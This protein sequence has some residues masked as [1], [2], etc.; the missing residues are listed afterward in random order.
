LDFCYYKWKME[1]RVRTLIPHLNYTSLAKLNVLPK[2]KIFT[3]KSVASLGGTTICPTLAKKLGPSEYGLF[4]EDV[5]EAILDNRSLSSIDMEEDVKKYYDP[6]KFVDLIKL[7]NTN[8]VEP[9][10]PQVEIKHQN[11]VGHPD[12]VSVTTIYDIKTTG[13]FGKMRTECILQL[14]SYYCLAQLNNLPITSVSLILP[15]QLKV[16]TYNISDWDWK[17]FY[18]LLTSCINNKKNKT[19]LWQPTITQAQQF[20]LL[21]N[22]FVGNHCPKDK[23]LDYIKILPSLQFFVNGNVMSKVNYTKLFVKQIKD[24]IVV[25]KKPVFIHAPY[26]LN[27]CQPGKKTEERAEDRHIEDDLGLLAW[28][29]WTFY[30]IKRLLAFGQK[31]GIKGVVVHCGR[32]CKKNYDESLATMR[33]SIIALSWFATKECK[34]LIETSAGQQGEVLSDPN[35]LAAFYNSLPHFAKDVVGIC[36]DSCHCF[37]ASFNP[38]QTIDILKNCNVELIH[39]NDS[40]GELGCKKDRHARIGHGFIGFDELYNVL[41]YAVQH[42]IPLLHE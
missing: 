7:I 37:S 40:K 17:P 29:G 30:T 18:N 27:L 8:L 19:S 25:N 6:A 36:I 42:N 31:T 5:I 10:Q 9:V 35:E 4:M 13:Q 14:L 21:H 34:L 28:G 26:C 39:Y 32:T 16:V 11:I 23:L 3:N 2:Q 33:D 20:V 24:A 15:L 12:L 41:L 1:H 22:Q 38:M